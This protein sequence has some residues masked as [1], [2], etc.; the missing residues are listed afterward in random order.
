VQ[1][2]TRLKRQLARQSATC[3]R[4]MLVVRTVCAR[5]TVTE[6]NATLLARAIEQLLQGNQALREEIERLKT[7]R[8][9]KPQGPRGAPVIRRTK[10]MISLDDSPV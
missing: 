8:G 3:E 6:H 4:A 7:T 9:E 2:R 10:R 5:E 1:E